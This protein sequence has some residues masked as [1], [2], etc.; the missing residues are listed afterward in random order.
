MDFQTNNPPEGKS[1]GR[2]D[3]NGFKYKDN[4]CLLT[5]KDLSNYLQ[6]SKAS[7][8][9]WVNESRIPHFKI[10]QGLRFKQEQIDQWMGKTCFR[11][12]R[13]TRKIKVH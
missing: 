11:P 3:A 2:K 8:Y 4:G 9:R 6:I 1:G 7:I 12:G 10:F 13:A 5:V